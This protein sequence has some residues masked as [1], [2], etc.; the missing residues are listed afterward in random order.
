MSN[1]WDSK[2]LKHIDVSN[3]KIVFEVGARY[4]SEN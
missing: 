2:F 1:Y 3:V 4:G